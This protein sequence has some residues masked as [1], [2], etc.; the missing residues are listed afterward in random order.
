MPATPC[1]VKQDDKSKK[2]EDDHAFWLK[3]Q[4]PK[5]VG[6]YKQGFGEKY[7]Y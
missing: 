3:K 4:G 6:K 2:D 7:S 5:I 1:Q